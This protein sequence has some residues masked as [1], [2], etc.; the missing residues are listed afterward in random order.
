MEFTP[1]EKKILAIVQGNL[2]DTLHPYDDVAKQCG[3]T[4]GEVIGLL[5]RLKDSGAIRR[6]GATL[7]HQRA[8]FGHNAMVA[9]VA[10]E[11]EAEKYGPI[12]ADHPAIS[13]AYFRP[14]QSADWPYTLYTMVHGKTRQECRDVVEELKGKWPL[15]ECAILESIAELKK[16]SMIYFP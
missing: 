15:K 8:G 14:A 5:S 2:P 3:V 6:F 11:E 9:W 10:T 4:T 7:R 16:T 12:V 1:E 13:H